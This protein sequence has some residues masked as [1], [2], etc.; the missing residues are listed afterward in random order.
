LAIAPNGQ[1]L[2]CA[3]GKQILLYDLRTET[4]GRVIASFV[5]DATSVTF[6]P[7]GLA[8]VCGS[9][10]QTVKRVGLAADKVEWQ[11]PGYWEQV[12]SVAL[13]SDG[14]LLATGSSDG[15]FAIRTLKA[16]E[17]GLE[18]GAARL[19]D[20]RTGRLLR[21][22]GTE[23]EQ[24]MG[25]AISPGGKCVVS[26]GAN[27]R[28]SGIVHA[29]DASTGAA[30]WS[31][32]D[33]AAE[34]LA[35]AFTSDGASLATAGADGLVKLR[36]P[37]TGAVVRTL[38]GHEGAATSLAFSPNGATLICGQGLGGARVWETST[39]RLLHTCKAPDSQA[40]TVTT[41][42]LL[43]SVSFSPDGATFMEGTASVGNTYGERARFWDVRTG[44]L[45][46]ELGGGR[47]IVLSPDG[48][49]MAA[50][51]KS[52][53]L[54]D[55]R[56]GEQVRRLTGHLKK[57]QSIVFSP[58]GRLIFAGGSYG[59]TNVWEVATGRHLLTLFAFSENR[60]GAV[61]DDWLA[62][63]PAGYYDGSP[64]VEK[65][66]AWRSGQ[67]LQTPATIG[68]QFRDPKRVAAN[69]SLASSKPVAP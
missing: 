67:E 65:Y 24:V 64:G 8:V 40:A 35:I 36:D 51:G 39:G 20:A 60:N 5:F 18:P 26:G 21:T 37:H 34:V 66:L 10:D 69:L 9:H 12:N 59:T 68:L 48:T 63:H 23:T 56:T 3:I 41:D 47:P 7:D 61:V 13:S 58:D 11:A 6:T 1:S 49:L 22:L 28:G 45:V 17:Q 46:R 4:A 43:T 53:S 50:G 42:R 31:A 62:Y 15:R 2:A 19:W 30:S 44:K 27:A 57:V 14:S 38:A 33:H 54:R 25:V 32:D 52:V 16:G 55:S 29:F